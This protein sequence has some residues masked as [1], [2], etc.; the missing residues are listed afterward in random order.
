MWRTLLWNLFARAEG[1]DSVSF[2]GEVRKVKIELKQRRSGKCAK[3]STVRYADDGRKCR[4]VAKRRVKR[5]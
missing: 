1:P 2:R 4:G 3:V 5:G